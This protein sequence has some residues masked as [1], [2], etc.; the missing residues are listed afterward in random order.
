MVDSVERRRT[1]GLSRKLL[2]ASGAVRPRLHEALKF[3]V[4]HLEATKMHCCE[5][6]ESSANG[7]VI[8]LEKKRVPSRRV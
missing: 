3:E 2:H 8:V 1:E 4:V 7:I 6:V 5:V